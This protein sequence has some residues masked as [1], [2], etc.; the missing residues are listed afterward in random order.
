MY[1]ESKWSRRN[2]DYIIIII[3]IIIIIKFAGLDQ[4]LTVC[5][6]VLKKRKH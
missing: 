2:K 4:E 3:I 6:T 5:L 1:L